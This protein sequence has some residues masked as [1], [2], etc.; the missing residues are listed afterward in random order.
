VLAAAEAFNVADDHTLAMEVE[1]LELVIR[2]TG[3]R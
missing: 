2:P 3:S 1:Y